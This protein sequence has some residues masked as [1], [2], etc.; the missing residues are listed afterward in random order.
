MAPTN[1]NKNLADIW[2]RSYLVTLKKNY[3][4]MISHILSSNHPKIC[5]DTFNS[6]RNI[7]ICYQL[8]LLPRLICL[9]NSN[10]FNLIFTININSM[11][12]RIKSL[13][14]HRFHGVWNRTFLLPQSIETIQWQEEPKFLPFCLAKL[15]LWMKSRIV[16]IFLFF[17]Q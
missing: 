16:I 14:G 17:Y 10:G 9:V 12:L 2:D 1:C 13:C 5:F 4:T 11:P 8:P 3:T 6:Y 7:Y 15:T